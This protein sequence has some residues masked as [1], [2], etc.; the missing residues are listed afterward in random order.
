MTTGNTSLLGLALPVEGELNGT[1][2]DVVNASITSL[3]DSAV[4]GTT[5]LS[6]D[7]D[8]TLTDTVLAA[9]QARQAIIL[10][11]ASNGATT[12]NITAPAR[13]KAYIVINA[14]TGSIVLRGA[15][16]TTGVTI[17][18]GEKCLVGW[19]GSDF[20]KIATSVADGV[21]T[22]SAGTTGFT[23]NTATSG[24]VTLAGT[25]AVANGGTG[26]TSLSAAGI[27]TLNGT[28]TL[29]NK[30]LVNPLVTGST[31][32]GGA[33]ALYEGSDNGTNFVALKA[34]NALAAN[35]T[36]TLPTADGTNGQ[37]LATN[38][39][40]ALSWASGGGSQWTTSGS[41][42]YYNTGN[43]GIGTSS[44]GARLDVIGGAGRII[45]SGGSSNSPDSGAGTLNVYGATS[46]ITTR[47]GALRLE[48]FSNMAA[49][50]GTGIS[51]SARYITA[52]DSSY[53]FA[54]IG[55]YKET[56]GSGNGLG[57]L[58]FA[59]TDA[60]GNL[61]ERARI[62]SGGSLLVGTTTSQGKLTVAPD[63][64]AI[65]SGAWFTAGAN[66]GVLNLG[67]AIGNPARVRA[68]TPASRG[69]ASELGLTFDVVSSSGSTFESMRL[70]SDASLVL[71]SSS[72]QKTS[73]TTWS[74]PS[75]QRLKDNIRD[76]EKGLAELMQVRVC[77][78]EYNGKGGTVQGTKGLGVVA[79]EIMAVLPD[80]VATYDAKLNADDEETTAIKK[81]DA[82]EITWLLVKTV[83][84]QQAIITA[85]TARVAALESN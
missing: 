49:D 7:S 8:V 71:S 30:T 11:T 47:T 80:T 18:A 6:A 81:F 21:T 53:T 16:P 1:W 78:W 55:G 79:D 36:Y 32:V 43:V 12:R 44:P 58:A 46:G 10:W 27:A 24:A 82:T 39:S 51:F 35:V 26:A 85:L 72:A 73:G 28:E 19:N 50:A 15:G 45:P 48:S 83:Q 22:F 59:T 23:P 84:E 70:N 75:D 5:T 76:Y 25:L 57:Y 56:A 54:K 14:G 66:G 13:S 33:V 77:E 61:T 40:G 64:T 20:V 63:I 52:S 4:A 74:N 37:V 38:G 60:P 62:T 31:T 67:N 41:D 65:D 34:P 3:V 9:N 69:S 29:T 17:V 2:G 42:I 68:V